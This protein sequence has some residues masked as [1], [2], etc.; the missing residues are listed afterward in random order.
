MPSAEEVQ[1][2]PASIWLESQGRSYVRGSVL[3]VGCGSAPY[4]RLFPDCEWHGLDVRP[5]GEYQADA[6]QMP[7]EDDTFDTVFCTEMLHLC[8][9]PLL[10]VKECARV[11]KP[12]GH[13][14]VTVPNTYQDDDTALWDIK[15]RGLDYLFAACGLSGVV[16]ASSGKLFSN[17]FSDY[18]NFSKYQ[19]SIPEIAGWLDHMDSRYPCVTL[20]VARKEVAPDA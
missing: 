19:I 5:V 7:L 16:L 11:L 17:E 6:H 13:L 1:K 18:S 15:K 14:V 8:P 9:A 20:G 4:R 10:V 3:D 12:G 2:Y